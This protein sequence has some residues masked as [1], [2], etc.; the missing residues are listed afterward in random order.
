LEF[1]AILIC[2]CLYS[3][4]FASEDKTIKYNQDDFFQ[5]VLKA[6]DQKEIQK[7][8]GRPDAVETY[9]EV[10][11]WYYR[12]PVTR[13]D[14]TLLNPAIHFVKGRVNI[15]NYLLPDEM[16][17]KIEMAKLRK[18]T[19]SS[20]GQ[21]KKI[22]SA[23]EIFSLTRHRTPEEVRQV[24]GEPDRIWERKGKTIWTYH[25]LIS[26]KGMIWDQ[27]LQFDY[28]RVNYDWVEKP[29]E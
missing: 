16:N 22:F 29:K 2:L 24:L 12:I 15:V 10:T 14:N 11:I 18:K 3:S 6:K 28:G 13:P 23:G 25:K 19:L 7:S 5:L 9:D 20:V 17:Q 8:F 27:H 1:L 21:G 4:A 26:A